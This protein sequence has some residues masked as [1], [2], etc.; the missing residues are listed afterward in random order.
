MQNA[1][2]RNKWRVHG[3]VTS[4]R[5]AIQRTITVTLLVIIV[6]DLV[7]LCVNLIYAPYQ[8]VRS[9]I[10]TTLLS[11]VLSAYVVYNAAMG[12]YR[13]YQMKN[14]LAE[15]NRL[16]PH[17]GLLNRRTFIEIAETVSSSPES[18]V[19]MLVDVDA[20]KKINDTYG[21]PAGDH[22]ISELAALM[23]SVF[24]PPAVVA[25]LGGE[26][27][28]AL[29]VPARIDDAQAM[30]GTFLRRLAATDFSTDGHAL[31]ITVSVG[32][33]EFLPGLSFAEI[34]A[35]ADRAMYASKAAG[36]GRIT[37][38]SPPVAG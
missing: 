1:P 8:I 33:A 31:R 29:L 30:A 7:D 9:A 16:D 3:E 35:R 22:V 20:F 17:T 5:E 27:F 38:F 12:N 14:H 24:G 26:E 6:A 11:G 25:R 36:G 10:Q 4:R 37:V 21:H 19:L 28:S 34:Y 15:L 23:K 13:V 2:P 18:H 32:L